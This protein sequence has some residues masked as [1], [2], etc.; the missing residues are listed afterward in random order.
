M[1]ALDFFGGFK[2]T[3]QHLTRPT[4][5]TSYPKA[6]RPKQPRQHGRHV[7]NPVSYTHLDVYKRQSLVVDEQFGLGVDRVGSVGEGELEHLGLGDRLGRARLD[8]E[9]TVDAAQIVDLVDVAVALTGAHGVVGRVVQAAHVD[10][11]LLYTSR[12]V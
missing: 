1:G 7:L 11:C 9:V 5:T 4:V 3:F 2:L 8:A 10:A 12:C 6:K